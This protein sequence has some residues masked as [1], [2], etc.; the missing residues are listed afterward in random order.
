MTYEEYMNTLEEQILN[1]R[2]KNL[3]R[4]E[5]QNHIE[6]QAES[7][8]AEGMD[9]NAALTEAVRQMGD[10]VAAGQELNKIHRPRFPVRLFALM[11]VLTVF[12]IC[13]QGIIFS[14]GAGEYAGVNVQNTWISSSVSYLA[15]TIFYNCLGLVLILG[16]LYFNYNYFIKYIHVLYGLYLFVIIGLNFL[17]Y[18][19]S[20]YWVWNYF[21]WMAYPLIFAGLLYRFRSL[22]VR[23]IL[24]CEGLTFLFFFVKILFPGMAAFAGAT[25]ECYLVVTILL[26]LAIFKGLFGPKSKKLFAASG[27]LILPPALFLL[28]S[29]LGRF[30]AYYLERLKNILKFLS[31]SRPEGE[32]YYMLNHL[33]ES[34]SQYALV[35]GSTLP[36]YIPAGELY[37][38]YMLTSVFSWFGVIPG[39]LTLALFIVFCLA[40]LSVSLRQKNR[41]GMMLGSACSISILVRVLAYTFS[42]FG[43]GP[44]SYI[45]IPFFSYGCLSSLVN[46]VFVGMILC[47]Y[48]N[49]SILKEECY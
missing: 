12:G 45:S 23:G 28:L 26:L 40:A 41:I 1:K 46:A 10:P 34:I 13:M 15:K 4:Q 16:I 17:V 29:L 7:Y 14:Q 38:N 48:R 5:F 35:G 30:P 21:I 22:G 43:Y 37:S 39:L 33:R 31:F 11:T 6:E 24:L 18:S 8:E 42:N 25:L 49:S 47:V 20:A 32:T 19:Y 3:V 36:D 2:A 44:Y 9:K 27:L